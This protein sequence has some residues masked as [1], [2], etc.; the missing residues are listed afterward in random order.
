VLLVSQ[1]WHVALLSQ[2]RPFEQRRH[3]DDHDDDAGDAAAAA[4]AAALAQHD[5]PA[6]K[7]SETDG[8]LE[9]DPNSTL[10]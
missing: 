9:R 5:E 6:T 1:H 8:F 4:L 3:A 10:N 7:P 2:W